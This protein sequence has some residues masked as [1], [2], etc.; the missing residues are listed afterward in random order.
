VERPTP[1][2]VT[3]TPDATGGARDVTSVILV[4]V[5]PVTTKTTTG[6]TESA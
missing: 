4:A 1:A 6:E 3:A 5:A 2:N